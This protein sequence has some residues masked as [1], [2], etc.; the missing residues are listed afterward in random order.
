[1]I[2]K[3]RNQVH[4]AIAERR[5][6]FD[7]SRYPQQYRQQVT[8]LAG[9]HTLKLSE[10]DFKFSDGKLSLRDGLR[11]LHPNHRLLYETILLLNPK[12]AIEIGCGGGDHLHNLS[13]L[14]PNLRLQGFDRSEEQLRFLHE[15][16]PELQAPVDVLDITLPYSRLLPTADVCYTQ[17]VIMHIQAGNGHLVALSNLFHLATKQVVLMENW[18]RHAF[19]DDIQMLFDEK[20]IPWNDL[21]FYFRRSPELDNRPHIMV[22]SSEILDFEPL[23]A[24]G[25][26]G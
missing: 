18:T 4:A 25:Q 22:V 23:T 21:R 15:R 20:M 11:P 9:E 13:L 8:E 12:T 6:D 14:Q 17:A 2:F 5:D 16:S 19:M 1:M 7:W 10:G 26:L 3:K 24:Y